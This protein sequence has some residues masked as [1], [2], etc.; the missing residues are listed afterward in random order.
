MLIFITKQLL[1]CINVVSGLGLHVV[2][3]CRADN[4]PDNRTNFVITASSRVGFDCELNNR[5]H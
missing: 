5:I 1:N 2:L 3:Q 4:Y